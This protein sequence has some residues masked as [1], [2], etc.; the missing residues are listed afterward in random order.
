VLTYNLFVIKKI[1]NMKSYLNIIIIVLCAICLACSKIKDESEREELNDIITYIITYGDVIRSEENNLVESV[2]SGK[3]GFTV[4]TSE[5]KQVISGFG[6]AF[7]EHGWE[8]LCVLDKSDRDKILKSVFSTDEANLSYGRIPIGA[9]DY[10]LERYTLAPIKDDFE[11][12]NFTLK[13]D[14]KYLIPFIKAVQSIRPDIKLWGSAW[15]PPIW[16]KDNNNYE[17]GNFI[18]HPEYYKAYALYLAKFAEE[19]GR[20]GMEITSVAVQNEPVVVTGYPNG[21]WTPEQFRTFIKDFMGPTFAERKLSTRIMLGTF[22]D[23]RYNTFVKT[24]L[25]DADA[26]KYVGIIGLQ[27]DADQQMPD[28][29]KNHPGIPIMQTETDCGNWHWKP[30][31]DPEHAA[32]DFDYAAYTWMR[33]KSYFSNGAESYMLWNIILDQHGKNNDKIKRWPQNSAVV[34]NTKTKEIIYTPMFRA[35]EHFSRYIPTG[36][37]YLEP[38]G[39]FDEVVSFLQPDGTIVVELLNDSSNKRIV[40]GNI[41]GKLY[42]IVMLPKSFATLIIKKGKK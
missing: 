5:T 33:M 39:S 25:D 7:N 4:R 34:I 36:S 28:I 1:I 27:W 42:S 20:L 24:V 18:D 6:G 19:Y 10:A 31:F 3:A 9:S 8:T 14:K 30:G 15:T 21:G 37:K 40:I 12:K 32:N 11:M 17:A 2:T 22:N 38:E 23:N 16:M 41:E 26:K 29:I 13:R 35:F